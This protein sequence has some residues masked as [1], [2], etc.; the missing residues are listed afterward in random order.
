[1]T[2]IQAVILAGGR[3]TRLGA[4]TTH[5][6]KPMVSFHGR[7]FLAY[8]LELLR[9]QGVQQVVLLLGYQAEH[10]R[11][12]FGDGQRYGVKI[13]YSVAPPETETG[14]RLRQALPLLAPE[15]LLMYCDNYWPLNLASL[16]QARA[17]QKA[18][19]MVVVYTNRDGYTRNN[20]H[21]DDA[22]CVVAYDPT[23][24]AAELNGVEIGYALLPKSAL[25]QIPAGNVVFQ[26]VMYPQFIADG[27]LKAF[28]TDHRYYSVGS[29]ERLP[30]TE[31][32]LRFRRAVILDRDGV[33][34]RKPPP[35]AY[36]RNR[37]EFEWLPGAIKALQLLKQAD[38]TICIA[39][40][41]PG[42]AR[43]VM[44]DDDLHEIHAHMQSELRQHDAE[45]DAIYYCPH[46]W[47]EGCS[48]RKPKPGLLFQAQR[49]HHLDLSRTYFIGDDERDWAA[50]LSAG[51]PVL[52]VT[53]EVSLLDCVQQH[54]P[55]HKVG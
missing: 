48:C 34:N 32:F 44:T 47:N 52:K 3:G 26:H 28:P 22:N 25:Q 10:V 9:A 49:A 13:L 20:V 14:E 4:L 11:E 30:L 16:Q 18:D 40:N 21:L 19:M 33:L 35:A 15:I 6:P 31:A 8:V 50:G 39:T 55:L 7:P 17:D 1:M 2:M 5:I 53:T 29:P 43:G 23:R 24:T 36:V 12:Y 27:R 54:I 46:G 42:I 45:V 51:C 38:Y 37:H 41:Q